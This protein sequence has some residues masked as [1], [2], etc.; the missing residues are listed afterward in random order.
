MTTL[1]RRYANNAIHAAFPL[2]GIGTGNISLGARGDLRDF[3]LF[4]HPDKG[5]KLPYSFF[6][7]RA[8]SGDAVD[9][10]ILEA[11]APPAF[12]HAR[13]HHPAW[14]AGM[15]RFQRSTLSVEYPIATVDF[16][17]ASFPLTV[18]LTAFTPFIPLCADD[19]SIPAA[20]FRYTVKNPTDHPVTVTV[21]ATMPNIHAFGGFDAFDNMLVQPGLRNTLCEEAGIR[22]LFMDGD[23]VAADHIRY[24]DN[25][26]MTEDSPVSA[27]T[28]WQKTGWWD[29]LY[30]FWAD[31]M[32]HPA[33]GGV[34]RRADDDNPRKGN[35]VGSLAIHKEVPAGGEA[36]FSF[37]LSWYV[38]NRPKG[39]HAAPYQDDCT[40]VRNHYATR[41]ASAWEAGKYLLEN[42]PRL[43][44]VS[45]RFAKAMYGSTLPEP[46]IDAAM[47]NIAALRSTTCFRLEDGSFAAWE[48]SHERTG[49]CPGTCTH[50]WNYAQTAAFLFPEL[51]RSARYNEFLRETDARGK[52][53]FRTNRVFGLP[54]FETL[55]AADGQLGTIVRAYR[56]WSLSGDDAFLRAI[57]P[58]L[59]LALAYVQAEWDLDGDELLE[60]RQHNTYDIEFY[61]VNPLTGVMYLAALA[62]MAHMARAAGEEELAANYEERRALS[63]QRLDAMTYN[64]E[65]Y[66]Q[67][68]EAVDDYPYQFGRG[69]LSDQLFGQTLAHLT[70]LGHLLPRKHIASAARSI[71]RHNFRP[72]M[73]GEV[74]MQRLYVAEDEGGLLVASWPDGGKP[75]LPFVYAEE[76]WTGIEYQVATLLVYEGLLEE[77]LEIVTA[78]RARQ[79]GY[80]RNPFNEMECGFHYARSLASWGLVAAYSGARY[81]AATDRETFEPRVCPDDFHCFYSNGRHWGMLHQERRP[82]GTIAQRAEIL[83]TADASRNSFCNSDATAGPAQ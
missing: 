40:T 59:K 75:A 8:D 44:D 71:H 57:W 15:P 65:Y 56:E 42:L 66:V 41:F 83:G 51:E 31:F 11:G 45:R 36:T 30:G 61:G 24:A 60:A 23:G 19:S 58:K 35:V 25:A 3:E 49:S 10:R 29:G 28:E 67:A 37:V 55:A 46:V 16:E 7:I 72:R 43:E 13:G 76:V 53:A 38:P 70:G 81:D 6:A 34:Q 22:G 82:D 48:G 68:L 63:A 33:L 18:S 17:D 62:A 47:S 26:I 69:C 54:P 39:W 9:A 77:A 79:D 52:M 4:N 78:V 32:G 5:C 21:A 64:G 1:P 73:A 2:G 27:I 20:L 12:Y 50:V 80:R 14:M 74:C